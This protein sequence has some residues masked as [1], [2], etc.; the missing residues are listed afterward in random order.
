[1]GV[2]RAHLSRR[3]WSYLD[4]FSADRFS[5]PVETLGACCEGFPA[6]RVPAACNRAAAILTLDQIRLRIVHARELP[7][8]HAC[9]LRLAK[10]GRSKRA[11]ASLSPAAWARRMRARRRLRLRQQPSPLPQR[12]AAA[13]PSSSSHSHAGHTQRR[14]ADGSRVAIGQ[15]HGSAP[16]LYPAWLQGSSSAGVDVLLAEVD[17]SLCRLIAVRATVKAS[18]WSQYLGFEAR[19]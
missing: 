6:G 5:S 11:C 2:G 4:L 13:S 8:P 7:H 18:A 19:Q 12:F 17:T 3:S 1:M 10:L 16:P 14:L 15:T 9:R